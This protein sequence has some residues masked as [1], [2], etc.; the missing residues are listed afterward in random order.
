[1]K[2]HYIHKLIAQGEHQQLDFKF[3]IADS[4]KIAKTFVAFS[5]T[6]GGKL[7]I[8]VKD[9]GVIAG[10]RS[11]EEKFMAEAAAQMYCSPNIKFDLKEWIVD[12]KKVLEVS[13]PKGIEKPYYAQ[14]E[15]GKW[16]VYIRVNDQNI[17]AN[18]VLINAWKRKARPEGT[19]INYSNKE[20]LLLEYLEVNDSI[21][22]SKFRKLAKTTAYKAENILTNFLALDII[23]IDI[24]EKKI[25]YRLSPKF[26]EEGA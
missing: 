18:K 22:L 17:L 1:M 12:G 5:N 19:Y 2:P 14:N 9:N 3:E 15:D 20:R 21:S 7:L 6:D 13:I 23:E 16:M 26:K 10:V 8:G 24:S 4:R 11:E 25:V